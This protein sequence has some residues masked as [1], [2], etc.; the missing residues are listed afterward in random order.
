[1][2]TSNLTKPQQTRK[3][4]NFELLKLIAARVALRVG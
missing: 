3:K 1:M 4:P 2:R